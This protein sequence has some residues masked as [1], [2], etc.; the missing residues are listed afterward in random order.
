ML[1]DSKEGEGTT[2]RA[3]FPATLDPMLES[4]V[5][6]MV[7]MV[8]DNDPYVLEITRNL[9]HNLDHDALGAGSGQEAVDLFI[10]RHREIDGVFLDKTMSGMS[11]L[12]CFNRIKEIDPNVPVVIMTGFDESSVQSDFG[13]NSV[14]AILPKPFQVSGLLEALSSIQRVKGEA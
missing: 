14:A 4:S 11:G 1:V 8:V 12:D 10:K 7:L 3:L 6:R 5:K 9:L 13:S 2:V